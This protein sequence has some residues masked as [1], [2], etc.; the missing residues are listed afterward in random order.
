MDLKSDVESLCFRDLQCCF[1]VI[2][3]RSNDGISKQRSSSL[4]DKLCR[5]FEYQRSE[6]KQV[7]LED[8]W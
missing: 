8:R 1:G 3:T 2:H 5:R 4:R 7:L 6:G